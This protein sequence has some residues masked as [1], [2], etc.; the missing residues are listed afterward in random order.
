MAQTGKFCSGQVEPQSTKKVE[1]AVPEVDE[2]CDN[3][4]RSWT[5]KCEFGFVQDGLSGGD[6]VGA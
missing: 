3:G 2:L 5:E 6:T 4:Y 1:F